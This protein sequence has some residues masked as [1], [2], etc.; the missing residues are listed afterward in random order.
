M[1]TSRTTNQ[2]TPTSDDRHTTKDITLEAKDDPHHGDQTAIGARRD[3]RP[4][5]SYQVPPLGYTWWYVDGLSDDGR[6]GITVIAF[7]GSVFSP[8]YRRTRQELGASTDPRD[9]CAFN[10]ALYGCGRSKW[11]MTERD[12][13]ALGQH[14]QQLQIGPSSLRWEGD[15]LIGEFNEITKPLPGNVRGSFRLTPLSSNNHTFTIDHNGLHRWR[16]LAPK[17]RMEVELHEPQLS[18]RGSAYLDTNAGDEPLEDGFSA[19]QWSR[20]E[21]QDGAVVI[22]DAQPRQGDAHVIACELCPEQ[23]PRPISLATAVELPKTMWRIPRR[24]FADEPKAAKVTRS[25]EDTPFYSR[26]VVETTLEGKQL[27]AVHESLSMDRFVRGST[28][29]MLPWRMP[30]DASS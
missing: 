8:Y 26:S 23:Q 14:Q 7:I 25:L 4:D 21:T 12:R 17:A 27:T 1:S 18:W 16:P 2:P 30:R 13:Y 19:W 28:Q 5:F 20:A 15:Q 29:W 24:M 9:H 11:A 22:Y 3:W 6:Y 10:V